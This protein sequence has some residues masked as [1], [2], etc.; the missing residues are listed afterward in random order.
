L[1]VVL[2]LVGCKV[3]NKLIVKGQEF[4]GHQDNSTKPTGG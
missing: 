2:L 1:E 4:Y 3:G